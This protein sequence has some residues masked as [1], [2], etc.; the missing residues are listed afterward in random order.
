[1]LLFPFLAA[2]PAPGS[3]DAEF[4][5]WVELEVDHGEAEIL[6]VF[7]LEAVQ[8]IKERG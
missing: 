6:R 4:G 8:L 5:V 1:M 7:K 2:W 3:A